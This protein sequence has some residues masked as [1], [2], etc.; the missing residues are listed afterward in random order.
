M[1]QTQLQ[2]P[3]HPPADTPL[4]GES[5]S[6]QAPTKTPKIRPKH[7]PPSRRAP[8]DSLR[9]KG[10]GTRRKWL[11]EYRTPESSALGSLSPLGSLSLWPKVPPHPSPLP[12]ATHSHPLICVSPSAKFSG[13]IRLGGCSRARSWEPRAGRREAG[14]PWCRLRKASGWRLLAAQLGLTSFSSNGA[15]EGGR[16]EGPGGGRAAGGGWLRGGR[17]SGSVLRAVVAQGSSGAATPEP[18]PPPQLRVCEVPF[19]DAGGRREGVG[20]ARRHQGAQ[21]QRLLWAPMCPARALS[22]RTPDAPAGQNPKTPEPLGQQRPAASLRARARPIFLLPDPARRVRAECDLQTEARGRGGGVW[23]KPRFG[24]GGPTWHW[25]P[26]P[27]LPIRG[28]GGVSS[29]KNR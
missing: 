8:A 14:R 6:E 9:G 2:A 11:G 12:R 27:S 26:P 15:R 10:R 28:G 3:S 17:G 23:Q 22:P 20:C 24:R 4:P 18:S 1:D 21:C 16:R 13:N 29:G 5:T 19:A 7:R 25:L